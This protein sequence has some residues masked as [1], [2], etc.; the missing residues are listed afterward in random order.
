M[1]SPQQGRPAPQSALEPMDAP[2]TSQSCSRPATI[3]PACPHR[4][5]IIG[6]DISAS[7]APVCPRPTLGVPVRLRGH[8]PAPGAV[9]PPSRPH[10][11]ASRGAPSRGSILGSAPSSPTS[12]R[13]EPLHAVGPFPTLFLFLRP[14]FCDEPA[15]FHPLGDLPRKQL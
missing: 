11:W 4:Q 3:R 12:S 5:V 15:Q 6:D 1:W 8:G 2:L 14:L 10:C 13:K 9:A 7:T